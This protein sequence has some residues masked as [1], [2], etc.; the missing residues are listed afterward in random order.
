MGG[1]VVAAGLL[2]LDS[3][4]CATARLAR[5]FARRV[6]ARRKVTQ[7][8][9]NAAGLTAAAAAAKTEGAAHGRARS[10][11]PTSALPYTVV[12]MG[13]RSTSVRVHVEGEW[14]RV[15]SNALS[16]AAAVDFHLVRSSCRHR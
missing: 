1:C 11:K 9:K 2:T 10:A 3:F 13:V 15:R 14:E 7:V 16:A 4:L 5:S 6:S 12:R 8:P